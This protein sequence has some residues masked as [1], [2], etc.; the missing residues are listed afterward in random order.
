M[1]RWVLRF[2]PTLARFVAGRVTLDEPGRQLVDPR[3]APADGGTVSSDLGVLHRV[4]LTV[5]AVL[6]VLEAAGLVFGW[7]VVTRVQPT[8]PKVYPYTVIGLASMVI[9]MVLFARGGRGGRIIGRLLASIVVLFGAG[10]DI[11]VMNG[12][13]PS[14]DPTATTTTWTT[15][16]P[17]L[18]TVA[19]G[20]SVLLLGFPRDRWPRTRFLLAAFAGV[21]TLLGLLSYVYGSASLFHG[22]GLTGTS[23][24]LSTVG[25]LVICAALTARPD[26][27]PLSGL[28]ERYDSALLRYVL[29]PLV[30]VP[31]LPA[32]IAWA[33]GRFEPDMASAAAITQ[34]VTVVILVVIIIVAGS[35]QSRAR[36]SLTSER[37][38]LWDAFASTP[39][40]TAM[41]DLDGRL[42]LANTAMGRL[43]NTTEAHLSGNS[44][45]AF[46]ADHD[47]DAVGEALSEI[48]SGVDIVRMD[49]QLRRADGG[50]VWVDIGAAPV[51]DV[52]G[53]VT[54]VILQC[55]DL[56]D[57]KHLERV[58]S[59]Q[60]TRDPLT[61]LLN[62]E[63]LAKQLR[64]RDSTTAHGYVTTVVYADVDGLKAV[65]DTSGHAAGD[66]LLREV[67]RRL[68]SST[69]E[70]DILARV[71][72][73][74]FLVITTT[75]A[76]TPDPADSVVQRLRHELNGLVTAGTEVV[77]LSV[78][79]GAAV[80]DAGVDVA[81]AVA[82]ADSAMYADKRRRS[83]ES[84]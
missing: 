13:L 32:L 37:Q 48:R 55:N 30:A 5:S 67:A 7:E 43:L 46:V 45:L 40:A 25:L 24:V 66:D 27:P 51:R 18:A 53:Q 17:S 23:F 22:L 31:F 76:T 11:A 64:E 34:L 75:A 65:N 72:G 29:P 8:W 56:T 70:G 38:R 14:S 3:T 20:T 2:S 50:R 39:A 84:G 41:L 63:G 69:R 77:S 26:R 61:G 52:A 6:V 4:L 82:R 16:I 21:C 73:D 83:M 35:G 44:I 42:L 57:R 33:V 59:D 60:A 71:G 1:L 9:A 36:R 58:L 74:E 79:L 28:D 80:L 49:V 68:S 81:S 62:R 10:V 78:S 47:Q 19:I 15:A 12:W 54:F